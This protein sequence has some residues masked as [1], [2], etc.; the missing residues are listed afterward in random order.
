MIRVH[1]QRA[2]SLSA[3]DPLVAAAIYAVAAQYVEVVS[4]R[5]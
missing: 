3:F 4:S 5:G 2:S 1:A